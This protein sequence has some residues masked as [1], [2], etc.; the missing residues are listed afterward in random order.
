MP[1][2]QCEFTISNI[3]EQLQKDQWPVKPEHRPL[4]C[5]GAALAVASGLLEVKKK[6]KKKKKKII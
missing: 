5:T 2:Q 4:R 3:I 6:K 1:V